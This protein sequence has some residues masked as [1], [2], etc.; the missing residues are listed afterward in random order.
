[1]RR[2]VIALAAL[3]CI[4]AAQAQ[5]ADEDHSAHH[6]GAATPDASQRPAPAQTTMP[7]GGAMRA[8]M[9]RIQD[10]MNRIQQTTDPDQRRELM[11]QHLLALRDQVRAMRAAASRKTPMMGEDK[12]RGDQAAPEDAHAAHRQDDGRSDVQG[13]GDMKRKEMMDGGM[14]GGGMM[15]MH[16]RMEQRLD[17]IEQMLEQLIEREVVESGAR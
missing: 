2:I 15:R 7:E 10:L 11:N 16:Q 6:P 8:G 14:M 1:M 4:G 5:T 9:K 17:T 3:G 13:K 12:P